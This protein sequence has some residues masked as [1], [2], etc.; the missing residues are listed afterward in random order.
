MPT[1]AGSPPVGPQSPPVGP[2]KRDDQAHRER[3][4]RTV[5]IPAGP[6]R[7]GTDDP[8]QIPGDAEGPVRSVDVPAFRIDPVC[9]TNADF[10]AFVAD[11][12]YTTVAEEYGWSFVFAALLPADLRRRSPRAPGT[13][14]WRAV[15]GARWDRPEGPDSDVHARGD[16][17][18]VHIA[19]RDAEAFAAWCGMRLPTEVE[20]EKAARGGLDQARYPWGDDLTPQGEHFCNIWQG[21]F[22]TRNTLEDG[23][24]GTAPVRTF[25]P[26]GFGL[27]EVAGNVWEWCAD[28]WHRPLPSLGGDVRVVRGGS[29]LC[30][31]SYCTR[32]RVSARHASAAEDTSGNKGFRLAADA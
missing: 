28:R 27:Y 13:P 18:V 19:L 31:D 23:Y 24:L 11:T 12:G 5:L 16:H 6:F 22:P 2:Q 1:G 26:N 7:M 25:P 30:H 32:Y 3:I 17:P 10:A 21:I 20:W 8:E 4:E 9:V 29:Y 14:W 15:D